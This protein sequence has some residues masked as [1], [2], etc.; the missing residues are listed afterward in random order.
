M[1][2]VCLVLTN[3]FEEVE[4]IGTFAILRRSGLMVDIYSLTEGNA[5]GRFGLTCTELKP[6]SQL[7]A[8]QYDALV[9]PGGPQYA[10]LE[11]HAGVQSLIR[12]FITPDKVVAAICAS[13]TIL[14]H[15]GYLKGKKYTCFTSMNE[16]FGGQFTD[17]YVVVDGNIITG[18]SAAASIDFGFAIVEK[19]LG[20]EK[21][22]EVKQ[23]IYYKK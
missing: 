6:F 14:G 9:L 7:D 20:Q 23:S 16:D 5:T 19:L 11:K 22:E 1:K 4:A 3:G 2:K 10:E 12:R 18:Q 21:A 17:Q 13:P 8:S 15:A